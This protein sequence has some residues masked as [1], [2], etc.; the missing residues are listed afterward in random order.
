MGCFIS[1]TIFAFVDLYGQPGPFGWNII[2][3]IFKLDFVLI[4]IPG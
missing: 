2:V 3:A 1:L 4:A